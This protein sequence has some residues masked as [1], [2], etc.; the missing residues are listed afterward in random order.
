MSVEALRSLVVVGAGSAYASH[1]VLFEVER[2]RRVALGIAV[3]LVC[4]TTA[5]ADPGAEA[6]FS[7]GREM[8]KV[9]NYAEACEAFEESQ[10]L[11]PRA[12][13]LFN[14]ALCS[15]QL[16]KLAT[17][18]ALHRQLSQT[19]DTASRRAKSAELAAQLEPRVPRLKILVGEARKRTRRPPPQLEVR[20]NGILVTN[21]TDLPI[22]LGTNPITAVAP[23]FLD[24]SGQVSAEAEAA[25]VTVTI[26]LE[27][28]PD[29]RA[30]VGPADP[31]P[32]EPVEPPVDRP[33]S[34][35][36]KAYAVTSIAMG[37]VAVGGGLMFGYLAST[38]WNDAKTICG[39]DNECTDDQFARANPLREKASTRGTLATVM[40]V[41]GGV[42]VVVGVVLYVT[43]PSSTR[44]VAIAPTG[45]A[46]SAGVIVFGRF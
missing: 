7:R 6:A 39:D 45:S 40:S 18:L 1:D 3:L 32:P 12:D 19:L 36:R 11:R 42:A 16:G 10:R 33:A 43:T 24:W 13:T 20:V 34:S 8:L 37:G 30:G 31:D 14:I 2:I 4:A 28:D 21:Y 25:P 15:E 27:R 5:A 46:E 41:A 44:S 22:D 38:A 26:D 29:A 17:A 23:G 9:G 35:N